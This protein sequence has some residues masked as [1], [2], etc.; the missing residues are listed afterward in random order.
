MKHTS[1]NPRLQRTPSATPPSPLSR[2]P[3]GGPS[4]G[5]GTVLLFA[6]ATSCAPNFAPARVAAENGVARF[7]RSFNLSQF[8]EIYKGADS[9][10]RS[11]TTEG[12]FVDTLGRSR[13]QL[14]KCLAVKLTRWQAMRISGGT[15][16]LLVAD[17]TFERGA[18]SE[19]F[20]FLVDRGVARLVRY[21]IPPR[22]HNAKAA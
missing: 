21:S 14:G 15:V 6:L 12:V 20:E 17:S 3:L 19:E 2:K 8:Q 13:E 22:G 11:T 7:H 16:M 10:L 5:V 18:V 4:V 9:Q 1:P